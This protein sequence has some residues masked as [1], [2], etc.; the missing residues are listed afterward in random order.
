MVRALLRSCHSRTAA[1]PPLKWKFFFYCFSFL[2]LYRAHGRGGF[3]SQTAADPTRRLGAL[4]SRL[5]GTVT[6]SH[7]ILTLQALSSSLN[8][9][10]AKRGCLNR[11]KAFGSPLAVCPP[12]R[13]RP[14][15]LCR[16]LL[17]PFWFRRLSI[18]PIRGLRL[19]SQSQQ[20]P[21]KASWHCKPIG[22][23]RQGHEKP[24]QGN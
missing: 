7:K 14:F 10:T 4:T 1:K 8:A 24:K 9:G 16:L 19:P 22:P 15:A 2:F 18:A 21:T 17:C 5:W 3:G 20:L 11:G 6:A 23:S 12:E 13:P